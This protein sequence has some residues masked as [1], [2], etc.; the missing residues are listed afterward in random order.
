VKVSPGIDED[1]V[2]PG[3]EVEFIAVGWELREAV[4]WFGPLRTASRRAT[5]LPDGP[6]M[7][8][9]AFEPVP[10]TEP[11]RY[12]YEP[13]PAVIRAGLVEPLAGELG[14]S[15]LDPEIAYL[16]G[17]RL[18]ETPFAR[19]YAV[20]EW[21]PFNLKRLNARLRDLGVGDVVVKKRGSPLD[22]DD[23]RRRLRLHGTERRVLVLTHVR[24]RH[25]ALICRDLTAVPA[26]GQA[27]P[28]P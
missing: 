25:A 1:D 13:N 5:L 28:A 9:R 8:D 22:P 4:L 12:L 23:L 16:T 15:K 3:R 18:I 10:V 19:A 11:Q 21:L 6:T 20:E 17:P 14:A 2:P 24:G 7:T 27:G 26:A